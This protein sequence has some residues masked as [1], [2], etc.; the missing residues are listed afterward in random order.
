MRNRERKIKIDKKGEKIYVTNKRN[1]ERG[2]EGGYIRIEGEE[3][4]KKEGEEGRG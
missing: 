4:K 2:R 3:E 1:R